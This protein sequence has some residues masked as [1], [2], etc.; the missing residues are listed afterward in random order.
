MEAG[1]RNALWYITPA[2]LL[3]LFDNIGIPI[4][5]LRQIACV[6]GHYPPPSFQFRRAGRSW[7]PNEDDSEKL[8]GHGQFRSLE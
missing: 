7:V 5:G 8:R 4:F 1:K 3:S 2:L 6:A